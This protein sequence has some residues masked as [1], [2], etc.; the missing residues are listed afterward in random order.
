MI[1]ETAQ[2]IPALPSGHALD[3]FPVGIKW[4]KEVGSL[5]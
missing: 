5:V 4:A 3:F 1:N 2:F